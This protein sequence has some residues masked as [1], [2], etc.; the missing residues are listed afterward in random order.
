MVANVA[1]QYGQSLAS[2]GREYVDKKLEKYVSMSQI[3]YY[4]AV[5]THYVMKKLQ[6]LFF[7]YTH[8]VGGGSLVTTSPSSL[9]L[10]FL[11]GSFNIGVYK[12]T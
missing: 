1:M 4:F 8:T 11:V 10:C 5:D 2:Q 12:E 3:K 6:L 9:I 7:P